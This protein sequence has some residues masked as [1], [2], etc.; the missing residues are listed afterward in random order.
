MRFLLA[1]PE[2]RLLRA[3]AERVPAYL[4]PNHFTAL[5]TI[6]AVGT[7][8]A[9]ALTMY[10]PAWL[11]VASLML[12][13]NW[14]G[15]SLDGTLAR[16][17]RAERP[18]Y[19]YYLDHIVDAFSTIAIGVGLGLSPYVDFG[20]AMGLV[21]VYLVLSINVYLE[22]TVFGVFKLSYGRIGPTEVRLLLILVNATLAL[23]VRRPELLPTAIES[24]A[25]RVLVVLLLGMVS[26][27]V[28]R[29]VRNVRDLAKLEPQELRR[30]SRDA[31]AGSLPV[32]LEVVRRAADDQRA[33]APTR[34]TDGRDAGQAAL[35][36][37]VGG[38]G[39]AQRVPD[40]H[41]G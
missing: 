7:G 11:W 36:V 37:A 6:G 30:R 9:Y 18:R 5:G 25:N 10:D 35:V 41:A 24:V 2:R 31:S 33:V 29:F 8:A 34:D 12:A 17:R 21:L 3:I 13:V 39:K 40:D 16:V 14:F 26:L 22:S 32:S 20:V 19:G 1:A 28:L 23:A 4:R 15:D 27:L 38:R